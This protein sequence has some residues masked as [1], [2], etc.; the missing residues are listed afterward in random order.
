[1]S[2]AFRWEVWITRAPPCEQNVGQARAERVARSTSTGTGSISSTQQQHDHENRVR[3][4]WKVCS[5]LFNNLQ[6]N[7]HDFSVLFIYI[8]NSL[9]HTNPS[10]NAGSYSLE[11]LN[12]ISTDFLL[13]SG[14]P[15]LHGGNQ[16]RY[17]IPTVTYSPY[18]PACP[19]GC[20]VACSRPFSSTG[21]YRAKR[22]SSSRCIVERMYLFAAFSFGS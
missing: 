20:R 21:G 5:D 3:L 2:S 14:T 19:C 1:V 4:Q 13:Q 8:A 18:A 22:S 15:S 12:T 9:S 11:D 6:S 16:G 17:I 10:P 7:I